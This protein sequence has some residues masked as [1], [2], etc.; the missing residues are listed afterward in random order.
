MF[1]GFRLHFAILGQFGQIAALA[2]P[3]AA[4]APAA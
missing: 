3:H 4:G 2:S 1:I